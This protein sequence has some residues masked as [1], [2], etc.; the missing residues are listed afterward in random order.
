MRLLA[1]ALL[2]SALRCTSSDQGATFDAQ[3][4]RW[5][6]KDELG[7]SGLP[8]GVRPEPVVLPLSRRTLFVGLSAYRDLRCGRTVFDVFTKAAR[9]D[10]ITV[11]VVDQL[12]PGDRSCVEV[13]CTL[14][15][16]RRNKPDC[17]H[18]SQIRVKRI[19]FRDARGPTLARYHQQRLIR[20][21]ELCLQM[22]A[23]SL[24]NKGFDDALLD[25][26]QQT[27]NENAVLTTYVQDIADMGHLIGNHE[28]PHL[29]KTVVGEGGLPRNEQAIEADNLASP[30][31]TTLWGA[32]LSFSK[33]HAEL[34]VPYDPHLPQVFDG[35]EFSRAVRLWTHGYDM[36]TPSRG[37]VFHD[38]RHKL[39]QG[40]GQ[41]PWTADPPPE[42]AARKQQ[43]RDASNQRLR[44]LFKMPGASDEEL[45]EYGLGSA[46]SYEQFVAFSGVDPR[47]GT[48]SDGEQCGDV[49]WV[50]FNKELMLALPSTAPAA[51]FAAAAPAAAAPAAAAPAAA[52]PAAAAG[53]PA[54]LRGAVTAAAA[55]MHVGAAVKPMRSED[56]A[57]KVK[58]HAKLLLGGALGLLFFVGPGRKMLLRRLKQ[59]NPGGRHTV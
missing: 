11:G 47:I 16:E 32:G 2:A 33:C 41:Q 34:R 14:M 49:A 56:I 39:M 42:E 15:N 5:P 55:P 21:E 48:T 10:L 35:E 13:Y 6:V 12:A 57:K 24:V 19:D 23:H 59:W 37:I 8:E 51:K 40:K 27:R 45:G 3:M 46:R 17:P 18:K 7:L 31:L 53:A 1:A 4:H 26:L 36:Y 44:T 22:D 50:P 38:Y 9:P 28:I 52:A 58:L 29:C 43:E 30:K 25:Q 54:L 20:G